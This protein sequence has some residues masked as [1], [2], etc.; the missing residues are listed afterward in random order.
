MQG[1]ITISWCLPQDAI[2]PIPQHSLSPANIYPILIWC[3]PLPS[4]WKGWGG[5][6][7]AGEEAVDRL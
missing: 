3:C 4:L 7:S 1:R 2:G 6:I 5:G